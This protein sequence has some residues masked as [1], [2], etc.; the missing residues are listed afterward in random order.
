MHL[1]ALMRAFTSITAIVETNPFAMLLL[2]WCLAFA[3]ALK[4]LF[5]FTCRIQNPDIPRA[6]RV[7]AP[8]GAAG[9]GQARLGANRTIRPGNKSPPIF[10]RDRRHVASKS[11]QKH[12][13]AKSYVNRRRKKIS[14]LS[15][16]HHRFTSGTRSALCSWL[17][18]S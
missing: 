9:R 15:P 2:L 17:P 1:A 13:Q 18:N 14:G 6:G 7:G 3:W 11:L 8:G 12:E 5:L 4:D 16:V 10:P